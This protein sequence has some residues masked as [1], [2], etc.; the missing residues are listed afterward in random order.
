MS[1]YLPDTALTALA[2][3]KDVYT[4]AQ[5]D[6]G[7]LVECRGQLKTV[8]GNQDIYSYQFQNHVL[9]R[10]E[11]DEVP[12]SA[13]KLFTPLAAACI[14]STRYL[15]Y[16]D[17]KNFIHGVQSRS[18]P[19]PEDTGL[20]QLH[21][22][23]A[24]YSQLTAITISK[25]NFQAIC[26]YYQTPNRDAAIELL[27]YSTKN[28]R[29]VAGAP[30]MTPNPP[31]PAPPPRVVDPPLYGTSITA[32]PVRNGLHVIPQSSLPVVYL[33]WDT[34][35]LCSFAGFSIEVETIRTLDLRFAPHT[36]LTTVDDG[37]TL[38]C[39]YTSS[40]NNHIKMI[41]IKDGK[42][43]EPQTVAT[44]TPRSA[45]AAVIPSR[46]RIVLF[47]Q[48]LN[49]EAGKVELQ[50]MTFQRLATSS[51]NPWPAAQ[52]KSTHLG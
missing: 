15:F 8:R 17:D 35:A 29:W 44:P 36:S 37:A 3:G 14:G 43:S 16:V 25:N 22:P 42:A 45:I 39:F 10:Y 11:D 1:P 7:V 32:V 24:H 26:L 38:Y 52:A 30:D 2:V 9:A 48:T 47:Y 27:S 41:A 5:T 6:E 19:W 31:P 4:Y 21:I 46:D 34:L 33:Q 40:Q 28:G 12:D 49:F 18:T 50:G 23:C 20:L 13:P 51:T